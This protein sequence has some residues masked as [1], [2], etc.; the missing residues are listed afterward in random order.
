MER[1]E[2]TKLDKLVEFLRGI[3]ADE[4]ITD[5]EL[6]QLEQYKKENDIDEELQ[7]EALAKL[8]LT[9]EALIELHK[10]VDKA[11]GDK[12]MIC[13]DGPKETVIWPCMHIVICHKE[14]CWNAVKDDGSGPGAGCPSCGKP[15][16]KVEKVYVQ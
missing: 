11:G 15:V 8:D 12:C 9:S 10:E 1:K 13:N 5:K 2:V 7:E 3:V 14:E 6:E 16:E 4:I